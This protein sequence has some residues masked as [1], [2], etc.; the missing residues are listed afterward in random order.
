[1]MSLPTS[2]TSAEAL[3]HTSGG[4][5][6]QDSKQEDPKA[7]D[8][9]FNY[10]VNDS[11]SQE[12]AFGSRVNDRDHSPP[13]SSVTTR[14]RDRRNPLSPRRSHRLQ[15]KT[16]DLSGKTPPGEGSGSSGKEA[17]SHPEALS[18][19]YPLPLSGA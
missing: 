5:E 16:Q 19:P 18:E 2:S 12:S 7:L 6:T 4:I 1:M 17:S 9:D 3:E 11:E 14:K 15:L 10:L 8:M 13:E